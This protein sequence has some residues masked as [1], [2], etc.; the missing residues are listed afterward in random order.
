MSDRQPLPNKRPLEAFDFSHEGIDYHATIGRFEDGGISELFLDA[1]K[2]GSA[3]NV[4]ARDAAVVLS[5]AR[6]YGTPI[7]V[8]RDALTKLHDGSCAG[9]VGIA[10][11]M[12]DFTE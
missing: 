5:V 1:G 7:E 12:A 3:V 8:I 11:Q 10:L 6:Q 9:A 2:T 4:M